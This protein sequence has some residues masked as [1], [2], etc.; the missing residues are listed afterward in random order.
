[1][2]KKNILGLLFFMGLFGVIISGMM[3]M[4]PEKSAT[5]YNRENQT[6]E[7]TLSGFPVIPSN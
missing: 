2:D 6:A 3:A 1:M 7:S 5:Q 4:Q